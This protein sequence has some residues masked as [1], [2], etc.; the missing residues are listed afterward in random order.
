MP[1]PKSSGMR[2]PARSGVRRLPPG[3]RA[4][5]I[6]PAKEEIVWKYTAEQSG[7]PNGTFHGLF[8]SSARRLPNGNTLIATGMNARIYQV[9]AR[10]RRYGS[11]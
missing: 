3:S 10:G 8:V 1:G 5:E 7:Q 2:A 6:D 9:T 11:R 4:V